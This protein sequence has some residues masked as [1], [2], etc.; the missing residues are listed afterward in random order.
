MHR[1]KSQKL[2]LAIL[3]EVCFP[4]QEKAGLGTHP[5]KGNGRSGAGLWQAGG[6]HQ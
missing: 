5:V 2:G 6:P 4:E 1:L 3:G